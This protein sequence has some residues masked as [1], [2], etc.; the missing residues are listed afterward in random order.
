MRRQIFLSGLVVLLLTQVAAFA[1]LA[2]PN[3]SGISIGHIHLYSKDPDAQKK[4]WTEALGAQGFTSNRVRGNS[5]GRPS[6]AAKD[7]GSHGQRL[8]W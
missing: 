8:W 6:P 7:C 2:A 4:I 1:Q 3:E 5:L